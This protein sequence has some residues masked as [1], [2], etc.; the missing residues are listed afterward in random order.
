ME[1]IFRKI[2][3]ECLQE[4]TGIIADAVVTKLDER[5]KDIKFISRDEAANA[6]GITLPT[7]DKRI[8][9]G[10]IRSKK[11]GRRVLIPE[12]EIINLI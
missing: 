6:M 11:I 5:P 12:A 7:L 3:I 10:E 9:S 2:M 1:E 8:K 4:S